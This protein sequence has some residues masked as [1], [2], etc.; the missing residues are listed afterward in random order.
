MHATLTATMFSIGDVAEQL[1]TTRRA[2][3]FYE[4][5]DLLKPKREGRNRLYTS[6][7]IERAR[8]ILHLQNMG[9][10]LDEVAPFITKT[11]PPHLDMIEAVASTRRR[12]VLDRIASLE[13]TDSLLQSHIRQLAE[14]ARGQDKL[15]L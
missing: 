8:L 5:Y 12:M 7:D 11:N 10:E 6:D 4:G 14:H 9:F 15:P 1:G 13:R 3:R 2:L